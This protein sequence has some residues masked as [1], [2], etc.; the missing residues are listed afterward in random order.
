MPVQLEKTMHRMN[1]V[2]P[3]RLRAFDQ[4]KALID[5]FGAVA[6]LGRED[7]HKLTLIVEELFTNTVNH[8]HRGD[9][10]APVFI[11]F[12]VDDGDV[13]LIY[14]DSAPQFDPL[15]AGNRTDIDSTTR[16]RKVGGL[17]IF[18]TIGL[19]EKADYSYVE[20]RN[21]ICLRLAA[22]RN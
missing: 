16:E 1:R 12:E 14:E 9:S 3:A 11:A 20:G 2:F 17:G 10:D 15:A 18:I 21:R 22:T 7:R 8:G 5:E 4:V 13:Q 19:T 6:E